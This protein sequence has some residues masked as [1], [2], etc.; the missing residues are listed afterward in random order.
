L[1]KEFAAAQRG[2]PLSVVLFDLDD[3]RPYCDRF[4]HAAGDEAL[5]TFSE[6]LARATRRMNLSA[7]FGG[8]A[9]LA[10][11]AGSPAE[12]A[13]VFAERVRGSMRERKLPAGSLT[14]SAGV[15]S[16]H[17]DMRSPDELLAAA[18]RALERARSQGGDCVRLFSPSH[19]EEQPSAAPRP[20]RAP[21][22]LEGLPARRVA[23][24]PAADPAPAAGAGS[25]PH[26]TPAA[27]RAAATSRPGVSDR[28]RQS[29]LEGARHLVEALEIRDPH[30]SGHHERVARYALE[31]ARALD[32]RGAEV[33]ALSLTLGAQLLDVGMIAVPADVLTRAGPLNEEELAL[34]RGHVRAGLGILQPLLTDEVT[35]AVVAGHHERWDG[36]GYP[37]G[38]RGEAIPLSARI[39]AVADTLDALTS[40]RPYRE[41]CAWERA[42][43]M[44]QEQGGSKF[45]PRVVAAFQAALPV[46]ERVF[47]S[48]RPATP[49]PAGPP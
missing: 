31:I 48:A 1:E 20:G 30:L 22:L 45:D 6:I 47:L 7:R 16:H 15:S 36:G 38:L 19:G 21:R 9:F 43:A 49:G 12:G 44:I 40:R 46:L 13:L 39:A 11:L 42:V 33:R 14:V 4:G 23:A 27:A 8:K 28:V 41:P 10:V 37:Q 17:R 5:R 32:P 18:E 24:D 29:L 34:V 25:D 2:R 35:L 3:F 26:G